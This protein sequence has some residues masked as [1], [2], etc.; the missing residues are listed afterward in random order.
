MAQPRL[1]DAITKE[2]KQQITQHLAVHLDQLV[3]PAVTVDN[4]LVDDSGKKL[5]YA[6]RF[7]LYVQR[8]SDQGHGQ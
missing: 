2:L 8:R 7:R 1:I 4:M 3:D 6:N 5:Y